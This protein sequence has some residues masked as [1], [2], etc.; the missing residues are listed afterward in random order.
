ME[1]ARRNGSSCQARRSASKD[2]TLAPGQ[3]VTL[4]H[5][6]ARPGQRLHR[7]RLRFHAAA[8]FCRLQLGQAEVENLVAPVFRDEQVFGFQVTMHDTFGLRGG[9]SG[10]DLLRVLKR[11]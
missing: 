6:H 3:L 9:E 8:E 7:R 4:P 5:H 1:S 2:R 11:V 10:G